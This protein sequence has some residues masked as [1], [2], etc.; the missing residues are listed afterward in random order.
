MS[1]SFEISAASYRSCV[2]GDIYYAVERHRFWELW[3]VK[4]AG[5]RGIRRV[6]SRR[7]ILPDAGSSGLPIVVGGTELE[8][9]RELNARL[10]SFHSRR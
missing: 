2:E 10:N 3:V 8:G 1:T 5:S 9:S 6:E 4:D 7:D